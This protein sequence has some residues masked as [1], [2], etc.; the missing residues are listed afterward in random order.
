[1]VEIA[2]HYKDN[3]VKQQECLGKIREASGLLLELVNEVL[4]MG[5][6][7][8][9][10]I[11]LESRPFHVLHLVHDITTIVEK[12]AAERGIEIISGVPSV[13]HPCLIG[14]PIHIQRL[15]MNIVSN[16]VKYNKENGKVILSCHEVR[17]TEDTAW[18]EFTCSDTGIGMSKEFQEHLFEPFT[19]ESHDAR[20]TYNGT[21]LG[22]AIVKNLLDKM[23]GT[24]DFPVKRMSAPLTGLRFLFVSTIT[25]LPLPKQ[26]LPMK[27]SL[28][29]A[30]IFCWLKIIC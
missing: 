11:V 5:K 9:G 12:Q 17:F 18:I 7:E 4:D 20:S 25:P 30:I 26:K 10:E 6:L 1:M 19:Q 22:M 24:I 16:A 2:G 14:S 28:F 29:P 23:G 21:G 27:K 3:P 8:S 13:Q 15:L